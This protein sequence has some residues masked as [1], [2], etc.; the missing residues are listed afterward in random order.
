MSRTEGS[1]QS[2]GG[3]IYFVATDFNPLK[4]VRYCH[5]DPEVSE[6]K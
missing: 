2:S 4:N 5:F 1:L 3:T 6:S